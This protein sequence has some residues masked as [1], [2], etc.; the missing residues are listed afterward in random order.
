MTKTVSAGV[1][2]I[3]ILVFLVLS[4]VNPSQVPGLDF[5]PFYT[6][7]YMVRT[8]KAEK[9][10]D[11]SELYKI[12]AIVLGRESML[13]V[14]PPFEAVILAPLSLLSIRGA[15]LAWGAM[16]I[17]LW[18]LSVILIC[19][20]APTSNRPILYILLSAACLPF[21]MNVIIGQNVALAFFAYA[22]VFRTI[23]RQR[24]IRAGAYLAIGLFRFQLILPFVLICMFAKQ[25]KILLGFISAS[26]ALG[27]LTIFAVGPKTIISYGTLML[28]LMMHMDDPRLAPEPYMFSVNYFL[29][30]LFGHAM[31]SGWINLIAGVL[32]L[33]MI[34][35]VAWRWDVANASK[36]SAA[37]AVCLIAGFHTVYYDLSLL[38]LPVLL[39]AGSG[40][41]RQK[42]GLKWVLPGTIAA[43]YLL[44]FILLLFGL[45]GVYLFCP[46]VA[47]F[48]FASLAS[49]PKFDLLDRVAGES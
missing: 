44:P 33:G 26:G 34:G 37:I 31:R 11:L 8:G 12:E 14:H 2:F 41:W 48:A 16:S 20:Y 10:Y 18:A 45:K 49:A 1:G 46:L 42:S 29:R 28:R 24:P 32:I 5:G 19:P 9:L 25:R 13:I 30:V 15:Y 23:K 21:W 43:F 47:V 4:S 38:L 3:G 35:L 39:V 6:S 17:L 7:G 27:L 36:F 40:E 22:M